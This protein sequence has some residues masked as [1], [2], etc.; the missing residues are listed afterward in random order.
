M[1]IVRKK[2][3]GVMGGALLLLGLAVFFLS[4][5]APWYGGP[6]FVACVILG[7]MLA[8]GIHRL[9]RSKRS[10]SVVEDSRDD[11]EAEPIEPK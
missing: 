2:R 4:V 3:A 9:R 1:I 11:R 8:V 5:V 7:A 10:V 6:I